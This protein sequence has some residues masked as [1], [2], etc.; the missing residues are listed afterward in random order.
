MFAFQAKGGGVRPGR[1]LTPVVVT[2]LLHSVLELPSVV[3][4]FPLSKDV[5]LGGQNVIL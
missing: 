1:V 2:D 4:G 3:W 5:V